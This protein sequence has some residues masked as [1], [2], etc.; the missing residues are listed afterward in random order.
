MNVR[1]SDRAIRLRVSRAELDQ[2]LSGRAV[3]LELSLP[4]GR[5]FRTNVRP[6]ALDVWQLDS[7]P[8]GF[9]ISLPRSELEV[10]AQTLPRKEGIEHRFETADGEVLVAFEVDLRD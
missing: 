7:D 3:A 1:F 8:T 9:W 10:F 2:L 4:R 6:A 5:R